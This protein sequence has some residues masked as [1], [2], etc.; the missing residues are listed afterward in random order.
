MTN[1]FDDI[2]AQWSF[3]KQKNTVILAGHYAL[4]ED[5]AEISNLGVAEALSFEMGIHL[6][7]KLKDAGQKAQLV[8]WINDIGISPTMRREIKENFVLPDN[9]LEILEVSLGSEGIEEVH[10]LFESTLRNRASKKLSSIYKA[11]QA[12]FEIVESS[13][14][15]LQRCIEYDHCNINEDKKAYSIQAP[16]GGRLVVKEG[17]NPKCNLILATLYDY[18]CRNECSEN[19]IISIFNI[20]YKNRLFLGQY[21]YSQLYKKK[22][23]F[24][25]FYT[26]FN[27]NIS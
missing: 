13:S 15:G 9:Y 6:Y 8:L 23:E 14:M 25:D 19:I 21:V 5:F 12:I 24:L 1:K 22:V 4:N 27:E 10:I 16:D 17:N 2:F 18:L 7:Q 11:N 3:P 20:I 26:D